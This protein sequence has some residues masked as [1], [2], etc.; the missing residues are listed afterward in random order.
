MFAFTQHNQSYSQQQ[1]WEMLP[2]NEDQ[3]QKIIKD[4][5]ETEKYDKLDDIVKKQLEEE[6]KK[7][8]EYMKEKTI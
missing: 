4:F 2:L 6:E 5:I 7:E 1:L 3:R 8:I